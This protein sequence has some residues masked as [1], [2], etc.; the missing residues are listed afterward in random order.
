MPWVEGDGGYGDLLKGK[1]RK[2]R[3]ITRAEKVERA[4]SRAVEKLGE[5]KAADVVAVFNNINY[6]TIIIQGVS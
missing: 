3:K 4:R 5:E 1:G 2:R 6:T